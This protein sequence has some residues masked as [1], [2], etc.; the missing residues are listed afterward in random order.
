MIRHGCIVILMS[1]ASVARGQ[2]EPTLSDLVPLMRPHL[3]AAID[4]KTYEHAKSWG[5]TA[6]APHALR[7]HGLRPEIQKTPQND[8]HWRKVRVSP[9]ELKNNLDF[10]VSNLQSLGEDKQSFQ[11]VVGFLATVEYEHQLWESGLRLYSGSTRARMRIDLTMDVENTMRMEPSKSGSFVP[12]IVVRLKATKAKLKTRD[13]VVE[14]TA[15]VGGSAA[16]LIGEAI[17]GI[18]HEFRPDLETRLQDR[19]AAAL[20]KAADTREVRIGLGSLLGG[21]K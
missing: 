6:M 5:R 1:V 3:I 8:G 20:V 11:I 9:R 16:R 7:W 18:I 15:G 14:H 2:G 19:A 12:D 13:L 4:G 10:R 17:E 21:K